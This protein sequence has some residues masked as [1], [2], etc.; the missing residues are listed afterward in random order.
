MVRRALKTNRWLVQEGV[1]VRPQGS[2]RNNTNVRKDSDMDLCA[3]HPGIQ[4]MVEPGL[5]VPDVHQ[6]FGYSFPTG[7]RIPDIAADLRREVHQALGATFGA[8]NVHGGNKA[9]RV[10]A[11]PGSRADIDVVPAI[12]LDFIRQGR[13]LLYS[14]GR[15]EEGVIIYAKDG[16]QTMNF[17]HQHHENGKAKRER[18][19]HRFKKVVRAA[20]RL[21]DELVSLGKL[22]RGQVPS[23]LVESLVYGVEDHVFLHDGDD[24]YGR[25]FRVL[26]RLGEQALDQSW[27]AAAREINDVKPLFLAGQSWSVADVR[28]F[29]ACALMR[30]RA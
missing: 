1:H 26:R 16:T 27:Q 30:L 21:R 8:L 15:K 4:V 19:A 2:Y 23:F 25:I 11:V 5:S 24:R 28:A 3:W 6:W 20:K 14:M 17:P 18:T 13:S 7:R 29:I 10:S 12:R 9:F 22:R